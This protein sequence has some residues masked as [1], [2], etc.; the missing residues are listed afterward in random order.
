M[1][2]LSSSFFSFD[3]TGNIQEVI[4]QERLEKEDEILV[5]LAGLKQVLLLLSSTFLCP[6]NLLILSPF[7]LFYS[8]CILLFCLLVAVLLVHQTLWCIFICNNKTQL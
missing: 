1:F 5:S 4:L 6:S 2:S 3:V 7:F 8:F